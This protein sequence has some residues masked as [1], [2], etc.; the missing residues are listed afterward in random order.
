MCFLP[1]QAVLSAERPILFRKG[2]LWSSR[3]ANLSSRRQSRPPAAKGQYPRQG[4]LCLR[5]L[6]QNALKAE[7]S[8]GFCCHQFVGYAVKHSPG[9]DGA[10]VINCRFWQGLLRE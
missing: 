7:L 8:A 10:S 4:S 5:M 3:D 2:M 9:A 6:S 1:K